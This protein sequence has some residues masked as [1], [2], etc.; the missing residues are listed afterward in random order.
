[1]NAKSITLL[2]LSFTLFS[3]CSMDSIYDG[4]APNALLPVEIQGDMAEFFDQENLAYFILTAKTIEANCEFPEDYYVTDIT[5]NRWFEPPM[6][7]SSFAV[8]NDR[9]R[10]ASFT[11][12]ETG[13]SYEW[14]EIDFKNYSL[15]VGW[16][17]DL[18]HP[19]SIV[20]QAIVKERGKLKL[21]IDLS[22]GVCDSDSMGYYAFLYPKLPDAQVVPIIRKVIHRANT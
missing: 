11:D 13:V 7:A 18:K 3:G 19:Q 4:T 17:Y 5:G 22:S 20:R 21:Y 14:P 2:I 1:M 8:I 15:L 16:V 6:L 12:P 10:L 9:S